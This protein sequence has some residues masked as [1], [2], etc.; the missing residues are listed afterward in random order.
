MEVFLNEQPKIA[1]EVSSPQRR[2]HLEQ[3]AA[4]RRTALWDCSTLHWL[5]HVLVGLFPP[6]PI[7]LLIPPPTLT[8]QCSAPHLKACAVP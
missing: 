2:R 6:C 3:A 1:A 8:V 4:S 5:S 7:W